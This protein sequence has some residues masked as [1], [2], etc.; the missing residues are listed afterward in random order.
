MLISGGGGWSVATPNMKCRVKGMTKGGAAREGMAAVMKGVV[1]YEVTSSV[2]Y[3]TDN[4]IRPT[5]R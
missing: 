2:D 4:I 5:L 1:L 3:E